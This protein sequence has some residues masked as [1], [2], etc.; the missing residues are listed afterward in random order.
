MFVE[1]TA[2]E[3][4]FIENAQGERV[5]T[6]ST[7]SKIQMDALCEAIGKQVFDL[8]TFT[9]GKKINIRTLEIL[10]IPPDSILATQ[11]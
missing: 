8:L 4:V 6:Y 11:P 3:F 9:V 5:G 10:E 2:D 7:R 1:R